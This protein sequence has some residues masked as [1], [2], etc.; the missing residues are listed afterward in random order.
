MYAM[1]ALHIALLDG[2]SGDAVKIRIDG[3]EVYRKEGVKTDLR[4]SRADGIDVDAGSGA[5]VE[6]EARGLEAAASVDP[7]RTPYLAV[8][9]DD[10]GRPQLRPSTEPFAYL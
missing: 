5:T 8:S 4:I 10:T 3:R 2:F 6:V 9:L 7:A 1:A